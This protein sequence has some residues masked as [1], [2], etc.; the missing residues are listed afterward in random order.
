MLFK[1]S[2]KNMKKSFKD[3]AIYFI[4][5]VLGVA[6]FYMFNS[7]DSQQAMLQVSSSTKEMIKL[8][9]EML[10][11]VS[12]FIA[13]ILGLLIVYA[14]NFLINRR[15]K[16]F[17]IY[18]TL[19][20][21]K[22][23]I[24]RIL[25]FETVFIGFISL[26]IGLIIGVFSSQLMSVLV[27]KL[28]KADMSGYEF[29][30]SKN[31]CIKTVIYFAIMYVAVLV[32]NAFTVSRYKLINLLTAIK[33]NE[34]IKMK[35]PIVCIF[36]FLISALGLAGA[37]Y[38]VTKG[39]FKLKN[40]HETSRA[41]GI[42]VL[43]GVICTVLIFWSFSGF[44]LKLIQSK[45]SLYLKGTNM[46]VLRQLHNKINTTVVSMSVIC[47]MLFVTITAL[48]SS[49]ALKNSMQA[50]IE[51]TTPVDI[52]LYKTANLPEKTM[53]SS[54]NEI[55]YSEELREDSRKN[56]SYTL[57][58]NGFDL[59]RLKNI[60]EIPIYVVDG[61]NWEKSLGGYASEIKQKFPMMELKTKEQ[62]IKASDY[63]KIASAYGKETFS[64]KNNEYVIICNHESIAQ[65]RNVALNG[66]TE[67]E[68]NGEKLRPKYESCKDGYIEISTSE[69]NVGIIIVPDSL[70]L[71][72]SDQQLWFLSAD[73]SALSKNEREKTEAYFADDSSS[74]VTKLNESGST[75]KGV[76]KIHLIEA[77]IG[78]STI[79]V[80]IA[81]Y[82][83]IVFLIVSCA[84]LA[85]KQLTESSDN[86]QRYIIL[87]KIGCD[88]KMINKA[89]FRQI[90]VFFCMPLVL[91]IIHSV[92][93]IQFALSIFETIASKSQLVPSVIASVIVIGVVYACYF[94]A[95]YLGSKNIIKEEN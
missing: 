20:M 10:G 82:L 48:S 3:Y 8:M 87:R 46:F 79:I 83:G 40:V 42:S 35:N 64:L 11:M 85:L 32:F 2:L 33:K 74:L 66:N 81:I 22:A 94:I 7:L 89:L 6:V 69:T 56:I 86:R 44:V 15:K 80:F 92:F 84:V 23:Q 5:L 76:T 25:L 63:N 75:L 55:T 49:I 50:D 73:Y 45:K 4:T 91:A 65:M 41:V 57:S 58:Q 59:N 28:F 31:A 60:N 68:I 71:S 78:L 14:N 27:A 72:A 47:L 16:E 95:T 12:V 1:L 39:V 18:L 53:D 54:G 70:N 29:V 67:I 93:G 52:N 21:G 77:S 30:F 61:L 62:I 43:T 26:V 13:V 38:E 19:G 36:V 88:E 90:A 17:G 9:I 34:R 51:K 24:S 37:Y